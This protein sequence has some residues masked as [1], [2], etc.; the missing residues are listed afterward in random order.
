MLVQTDVCSTG[1][2]IEPWGHGA[3]PFVTEKTITVRTYR[4]VEATACGI[5]GEIVPSE[6]VQVQGQGDSSINLD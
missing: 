3:H 5:D 1:T 4:G 6:S 2:Q